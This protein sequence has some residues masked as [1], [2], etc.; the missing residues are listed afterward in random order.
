[1]EAWISIAV[2]ALIFLL[3]PIFIRINVFADVA[4]KKI[5]FSLYLFRLFKLYGG[6]L[7]FDK[8]G[9]VFHITDK[10]AV[11]L[12]YCEMIDT[13][14]KFEVTRGFLVLK[15]S[16]VAEIGYS[17]DAAF[18]ILIVSLVNIFTG[19]AAGYLAVKKNCSAFS[20]DVILREDQ[21]CCK[22]SF[23]ATVMFNFAILLV[24]G[25]KILLRKIAE[26]AYE[27]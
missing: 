3:F 14:K 23:S 10:K 8:N 26:V 25:I 7:T 1:M 15:Y 20:G 16:Q 9:M 27:Q 5:Y 19:I 11:L 13:R 2:S 6:Y 22:I 12:P 24:A 4:Q 21:D 18:G 17:D